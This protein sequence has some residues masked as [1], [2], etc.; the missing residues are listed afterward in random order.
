MQ[1]TLY[2]LDDLTACLATLP[3]EHSPPQSV[4]GYSGCLRGAMRTWWTDWNLRSFTMASYSPT[5]SH[6]HWL[7]VLL[8][9]LQHVY[10]WRHNLNH[11]TPWSSIKLEEG[12]KQKSINPTE[13][14]N[15]SRSNRS[16]WKWER[17][18]KMGSVLTVCGG[19]PFAIVGK[20]GQ[21]HVKVRDHLS[22]QH[23]IRIKSQHRLPWLCWTQCLF[24]QSSFT[25]IIYTNYTFIT[26]LHC[27]MGVSERTCRLS[28]PA[29]C[30]AW[31]VSSTLLRS[32]I[33]TELLANSGISFNELCP[34]QSPLK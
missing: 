6:T 34:K 17:I 24:C 8:E 13:V 10:I 25:R 16:E 12:L 21:R 29:L 14:G 32:L 23:K 31:I 15:R 5:H 26:T 11:K 1:I 3:S 2:S 4:G 22:S 20:S 30:I 7:S 18:N 9:T 33:S 27:K 28:A 19:H